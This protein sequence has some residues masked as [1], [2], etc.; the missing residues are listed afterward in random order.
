MSVYNF[1]MAPINP[2]V[3][4]NYYDEESHKQALLNYVNSKNPVVFNKYD[5]KTAN[6]D[7]GINFIIGHINDIDLESNCITIEI[8]DQLHFITPTDYVIG[9]KLNTNGKYYDSKINAFRYVI[10]NVMYAT[11][12]N[13]DF[14]K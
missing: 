11:I 12:I 5:N 14:L 3:N 2:N 13:K 7:A 6:Y 8:D 10:D 9:F 1:K 4:E